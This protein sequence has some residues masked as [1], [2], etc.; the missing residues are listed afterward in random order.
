MKKLIVAAAA[1]LA[2]SA[3]M[4]QVTGIVEYDSHVMSGLAN[5]SGYYAVGLAKSTEYG[6]FDAYAQGVK[7]TSYAGVVD[8]LN[9][10]EFGYGGYFVNT[11]NLNPRIAY[12][13]MNNID[14]G[15]YV[16]NARYVLAS[17]EAST[18]ITG[19]FT[20]Y[21]SYSHMAG[22]N[23]AS[24]RSSNRVQLGVDTALSDTFTIRLGY[25]RIWQLDTIQNGVVVMGFYTF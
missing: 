7:A 2:M 19:P 12:G 20:G 23:D 14:L 3:A 6:I 1:A 15:G 4:A 11:I 8:N 5:K 9:G 17:L 10:W 22:T 13:A 25:S 21:T 16:G 18:A 24:I